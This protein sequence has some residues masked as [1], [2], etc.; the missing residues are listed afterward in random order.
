MVTVACMAISWL[1]EAISIRQGMLREP[2]D[3]LWLPSLKKVVL[4]SECWDMTVRSSMYEMRCVF[5]SEGS[6]F[7]AFR[8]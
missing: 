4:C 1:N 2:S 8:G 5:G 7:R 3:C 6:G